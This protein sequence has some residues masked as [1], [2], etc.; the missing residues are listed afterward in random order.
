MDPADDTTAQ[1]LKGPMSMARGRGGSW[2]AQGK[3]AKGSISGVR[4]VMETLSFI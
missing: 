2:V 1:V 4:V 3:W